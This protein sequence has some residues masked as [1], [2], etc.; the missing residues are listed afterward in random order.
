M[1][2]SEREGRKIM[3]EDVIYVSGEYIAELGKFMG[4]LSKE[5]QKN[6]DIKYAAYYKGISVCCSYILY[7]YKSRQEENSSESEEGEDSYEEIIQVHFEDPET[8]EEEQ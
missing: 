2:N 4:K 1:V 3:N 8:T 5:A 7:L 6:K